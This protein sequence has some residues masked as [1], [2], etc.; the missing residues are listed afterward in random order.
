MNEDLRLIILASVRQVLARYST[1][2]TV[3]VIA[4]TVQR[5]EF[6]AFGIPDVAKPF[7]SLTV[8][9]KPYCK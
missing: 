2:R 3:I 7:E 4:R 9:Y 1:L 8:S 5:I 6:G